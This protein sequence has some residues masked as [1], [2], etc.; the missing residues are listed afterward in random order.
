[1][2]LRH[3]IAGST[4]VGAFAT[5]ASPVAADGFVQP[6][7]ANADTQRW[8][9]RLCPFDLAL[10]RETTW[11][12]GTVH[13]EDAEA[14]FGRDSGLDE[15]RFHGDVNIRHR[16]RA[17]NGR[18]VEFHGRRLALDSRSVVVVV[19][20]DRAELRV[21][22]R[23][24]PRNISKDGLTPFAGGSELTLPGDWVAAFDT[25]G[26]ARLGDGLRLD[27]GTKRRRTTV[28]LRA[29]PRPDWWL[30]ADYSRETKS[31]TDETFVDF[32]YQSTG[33]A[34]PVEF[35]TEELAAST[36]LEGD[37]FTLAA[38]LRN[39]R[40]RNRNRALGWRN[41]WRGWAV[42]R[43]RKALA[44]DND[45][46]SLTL[47]SRKTLGAR[48]AAHATLAWSEAR[49]DATF[50]PYTTNPRLALGPLPAHSLD[51]R[52][53]SFAGTFH[54][55][56]RPTPALRLTAR[57][58]RTERDNRTPERTFMPVRGET[59]AVG[60]VASRAFDV[61]RS[62]TELGMTYRLAPRVTIGAYTETNRVRRAPAEIAANEERHHRIE[63]GV[64][65]VRGLRVK[66]TF[67]DA[68]RNA[69]EFHVMT[70]NNA[71]T[72]RYHQAAREQRTWRARLGYE[73]PDS[74][75]FVEVRAECGSNAYPESVLGLKRDRT[76]VR[77]G[78][79]AYAPSRKVSVGAFYL[80]QKSDSATAGMVGF[81][82]SEW[83]YAT[84]DGVDTLGLRVDAGA[85]SDGRLRFSVDYVRSLGTGRYRTELHGESFPFPDLVSNHSS[86]DLDARYRLGE[87]SALVFEL[88]HERYRGEDW[89][90]VEARDAIRNVLTFG[91]APPHY[92]INLIGVSYEAS[93]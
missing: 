29:D 71:L 70:G 53:R 36:A 13:V 79:I 77:G 26:M 2:R 87:G 74:G 47:V 69:A 51:G 80:R 34:K 89:A 62:A 48:V 17:R 30:R 84:V 3:V 59:F 61:E 33:L 78:D 32:L 24:L 63:L 90:L 11:S 83:R 81:T 37:S 19:G 46:R 9:C 44:P 14:R 56:A 41:P 38:E 50:E 82:G 55:L 1:M 91:S 27:R 31:G 68:E 35:L 45:A 42:L 6:N 57:H 43:G 93:F 92:A 66:L 40:F 67:A 75:A 4:L 16:Q 22:R 49:Q 28:R 7:Y 5:A 85:F 60:P 18:T 88:R 20:D 21:A 12:V 86:I 58:R 25:A 72:R 65:G 73:I 76:C 8:R 10:S 64:R 52:A 23:E 54:L 39:S 15:A